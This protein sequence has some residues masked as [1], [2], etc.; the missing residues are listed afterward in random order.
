MLTQPHFRMFV[1]FSFISVKFQAI[2]RMYL[3]FYN[4]LSLGFFSQVNKNGLLTSKRFSISLL[5]FAG[6]VH[7]WKSY[8]VSC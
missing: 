8:I 3:F 2:S 6:T 4:S 5:N 7:V 1:F